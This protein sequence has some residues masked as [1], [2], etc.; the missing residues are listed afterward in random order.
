M[1]KIWIG[2]DPEFAYTTRSGE[3]LRADT[4]QARLGCFGTD[5]RSDT[6]E[7]RPGKSRDVVTLVS[8]I[9]HILRLASLNPRI[10]EIRWLAGH[11]IDTK[12][13]GGHISISRVGWNYN[14]SSPDAME[15]VLT[16]ALDTLLFYGTSRTLDELR[17]RRS[18][19]RTRYGRLGNMCI[20]PGRFEYRSCGSWLISPEVALIYLGLAK[21]C[22]CWV[23]NQQASGLL[24]LPRG[25]RPHILREWNRLSAGVGY[26]GPTNRIK[27]LHATTEALDFLNSVMEL[28]RDCRVAIDTFKIVGTE[29]IDWSADLKTNWAVND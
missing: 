29:G 7:I 4:Y 16:K 6:G 23:V 11:Y 18:R 20:K 28:P 9:H 25:Q 17:Q 12:P 8:K 2:A 1:N 27:S 19:M 13:L 24:P 22:A 10:G 21:I 26:S 5:G 3:R 15:T 14:W